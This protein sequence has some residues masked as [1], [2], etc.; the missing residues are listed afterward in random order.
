[1]SVAITNQ[2]N[3]IKFALSN[4]DV[5]HID[6]DNISFKKK[7]GFVHIYGSEGVDQKSTKLRMK[8]SEVTSPSV[9]SNDLLIAELLGYKVN[10]GITVGDVKI[11]DGAEVLDIKE[12]PHTGSNEALVNLEG[13]ICENNTSL[14][15]LGIGGV[16]P[17]S[18]ED[19]IDFGTIIISVKS[20][21]ASAIDGLR[22]VWCSK[23][24]Y[25]RNWTL[26]V[27]EYPETL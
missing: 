12:N 18:W 1:M 3:T 21:Q 11:T 4:G 22:V 16:F 8:F 17:G 26:R 5:Y 10:T 27:F 13:H 19:N 2:A 23:N 7:L 6:K 20:D 14:T 9:A 25:V 24:K 15:P